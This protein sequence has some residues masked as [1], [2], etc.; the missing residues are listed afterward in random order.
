MGGIIVVDFIDMTSRAHQRQLYE[1]FKEFLRLDKAKHNVLPPSRFGV[2]EITRQRVREVTDI[3]TEEKCPCCSGSGKV[4]ASILLTDQIENNLRYLREEKDVK[5]ITLKVHPFVG[6]Y[7]R[8]GLI[9]K[10]RKWSLDLKISL[11]VIDDS[12]YSYLQYKFFDHS[13][14][15]IDL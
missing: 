12:D 7:L 5:K 2:V 11:K 1:K 10:R 14:E 8:S 13:G 6:A 15:L 3:S 9:S 4:Q